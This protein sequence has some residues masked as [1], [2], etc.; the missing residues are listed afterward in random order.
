MSEPQRSSQDP[1]ALD[2]SGGGLAMFVIF[3]TAVL[4]VTGT[5]VLVALV[6]GW[7]IVGAAVAIHVLMTALVIATIVTVMNGRTGVTELGRAP[8][9]QPGRP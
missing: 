4:L 3:T 8:A 5:V 1:V 7:W 9:S 2:D 6:G